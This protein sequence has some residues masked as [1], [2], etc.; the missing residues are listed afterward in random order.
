MS[1]LPDLSTEVGRFELLVL[2][3]VAV[4]VLTFPLLFFVSAP[5][6]RHARGGWGPRIDAT[7]GWLVM[8]APAP[9]VFALCYFLGDPAHTR[10][11]AAVAFLL[12]WQAHYLHRAFVF[13]FRRR[14]GQPDMPLLIAVFSF[15][16]NA[17][18][19]CLNGRW[20]FSLG[21]IHTGDWL[22]DPRFLAGVSLFALGYFINQHS[23]HILFHLRRPGETGYQIPRGGLYRLVSCPNYLGEILAWCGWA[24]L[25]FSLPGLAFAIWT[26]ANLVPRARTHHRWYREKFPDYPRERRAIVPFLF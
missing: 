10:T 26:A 7:V 25:T 13:P 2:G 15:A 23:D 6:G 14:G 4:A 9:I 3:F 24:L 8:E 22:A 21:P 19:G 16:F 20:L 17:I 11:P 5:Y 18:N 1:A 12:I